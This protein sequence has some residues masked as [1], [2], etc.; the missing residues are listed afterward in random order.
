MNKSNNDKLF[1]N[2]IKGIIIFFIFF[3]SVY[4]QYIPVILFKLN[5]KELSMSTKVLLSSF[6]SIILV[7][8]FIIV[9][10][11]DLKRDFSAFR[12]DI[13][14]YLDIGFKYWSVGLIIMFITNIIINVFFHAG[15]ANNENAVQ[16]MIKSFPLV[17]FITASFIGPFN[18][19]IVFRK[20][21]KDVFKNKWLFALAS[22]ILFGGA[23]VVS[24]ATVFTDYLYIVPYGA[25]GAAFALA[26]YESDNFFTSF[27][28]HMIHNT[29]LVL[30]SIIS[31]LK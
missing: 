27:S 3:N 20:T 23:H 8:L 31:V 6:S 9:Y 14:K 5:V 1:G 17:M 19:E 26:Y 30:I 11:K 16:E 25:L 29:I 13:S 7:L 28:M 22:F 12:K 18:E 10:R 21:L 4:L 2:I 24:S 15:G